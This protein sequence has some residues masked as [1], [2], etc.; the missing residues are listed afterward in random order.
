[1]P[2]LQGRDRGPSARVRFQQLPHSE[3][4]QPGRGR[5]LPKGWGRTL[6][7]MTR[8][9]RPAGLLVAA[10]LLAVLGPAG[11]ALAAKANNGGSAL[12]S[13]GSPKGIVTSASHASAVFTRT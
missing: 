2:L 6:M 7:S 9:P 10:V 12:I 13:T 3:P 11:T 4:V 5:A 8:V 1:M